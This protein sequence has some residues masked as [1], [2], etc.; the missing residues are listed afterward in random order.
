MFTETAKKIEEM[1]QLL[2]KIAK[3]LD[4][5]KLRKDVSARE[6][7]AGE[8]SFWTDSVKAKK[9]SKE[10]NDLKKTLTE[11]EK[12]EKVLEDLK[13]HC[14]LATEVGDEGEIKEVAKG[15]SGGVPDPAPPA[16]ARDLHAPRAD[17]VRLGCRRA[18]LSARG[19]RMEDLSA[20]WL[21]R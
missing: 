1:L 3:L 10:L 18:R 7:E 5:P 9:K 4:L 2:A 16:H 17:P 12:A 13:A 15:L 19:H 11:Y 20:P 6:A 21:R 8:P 14:E